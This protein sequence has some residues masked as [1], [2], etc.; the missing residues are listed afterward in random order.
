MLETVTI[1]AK[2]HSTCLASLYDRARSI[3]K[4]SN[5]KGRS[6]PR[7]IALAELVSYIEECRMNTECPVFR[8]VELSRLYS[9]RLEQLGVNS[10]GRPHTSRLKDR[11]SAQIPQLEADKQG[12][13]LLLA[14][15]EDVGLA[16]Q[17]VN[18]AESC[19]TEGLHLAKAANIVRRHMQE[20]K[21]SF[22][23]SFDK[24][25]QENSAPSS[26][27]CLVMILYGPNTESQSN[28]TA[29][30]SSLSIAQLMQYNSFVRRR[31]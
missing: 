14:F 26:L 10:D 16:L 31:G 6:S 19:D 23:G 15:K 22:N 9:S 25:C 12:R 3:S 28:S 13:D 24:M 30:Q 18:Y 8:L 2:H 4:E 27:P 1:E 17:R 11:L 5:D 20:L 21:Q 7:G 29:V